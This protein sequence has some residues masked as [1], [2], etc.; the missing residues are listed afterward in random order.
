M[1]NGSVT[2]STTS[3]D[4]LVNGIETDAYCVLNTTHYYMFVDGVKQTIVT[5]YNGSPD[6]SQNRGN[7]IGIDYSETSQKFNGTI[8]K[9]MVHNKTLLDE[10]IQILQNDGNYTEDKD[11]NPNSSISFN[12]INQ[13]IKTNYNATTNNITESSISFW[14]IIRPTGGLVEFVNSFDSVNLFGQRIYTNNCNQITYYVADFNAQ[15]SA[16]GLDYVTGSVCNEWHHIVGVLNETNIS[17]YLDGVKVEGESRL[18]YTFHDLNLYE[19]GAAEN[20][21]FS[22]GSM[23]KIRIYNRSL[24]DNEVFDLF[25]FEGGVGPVNT[26][27]TTTSIFWPNLNFSVNVSL[28]YLLSGGWDESPNCSIITNVSWLNCTPATQTVL[29]SDNYTDF[30]C[31]AYERNT[32]DVNLFAQCNST[33]NTYINSTNITKTVYA[34]S[35]SDVIINISRTYNNI[36]TN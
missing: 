5:P 36:L 34:D 18:S 2:F 3:N 6:Y 30:L 16:L 1:F 26:N 14:A 8:N 10:E 31:T 7:N 29:L 13:M 23:D 11:S 32:G 17:L 27:L 9:V 20:S 33:L 19:F 12:G 15:G 22:N 25:L 24:S 21:A 4:N 28:G 35:F